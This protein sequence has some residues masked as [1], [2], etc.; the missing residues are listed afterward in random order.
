MFKRY[1]RPLTVFSL[2]I[3]FC[4]SFLLLPI[5]CKAQENPETPENPEA[6]AAAAENAEPKADAEGCEDLAAFARLPG[7]II[8]SCQGGESV[9]VAMP[10]PPDAR[11]YPR[12]KQVRGGYEFREYQ[13]VQTDQREQAFDNLMELLPIAGFRVKYSAK[14]ETITARK[15]N[16]WILI[17]VNGEFYNV[18]QVSTKEESWTPSADAEAISRD[19][20]AHSRAA[21]YGIQFSDDNLTLLE[22]GKILSEVLRYLTTNPAL[23]VVVESHKMSEDGNAQDDQEITE[24]RAKALVAWL[25]SHGISE[26]RLQAKGLGRSKPLSENDTPLEIQRNERIE[27]VRVQS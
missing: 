13:I 3:V 7:S 24:K 26:K 20:L 2:P 25:E 4:A 15:E 23:A 8:Q 18:S 5:H 6:P 9:G 19:M 1:F 21:V 12:E 10:L 22:E 11:G 14:P 16:I 17:R 27:L